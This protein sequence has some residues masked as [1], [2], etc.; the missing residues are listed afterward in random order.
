MIRRDEPF[1]RHPVIEYL[2][3][4]HLAGESLADRLKKGPLP[5]DQVLHYDRPPTRS[6]S[7]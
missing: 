6:G 5:I 4:E 2:V 3:M 1:S 7:L